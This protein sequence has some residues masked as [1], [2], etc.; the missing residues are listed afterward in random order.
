MKTAA[1]IITLC[2]FGHLAL[3]ILC[4]APNVQSGVGG[5][6]DEHCLQIV[7]SECTFSIQLHNNTSEK[8]D[9]T[10]WWFD[11][12][13]NHNGSFNIAGGELQPGQTEDLIGIRECGIYWV[14]WS[15]DRYNHVYAFYQDEIS[16]NPRVLKPIAYAQETMR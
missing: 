11:H 7:Q 6:K 2:W 14:R 9:Y 15:S 13:Y 12:P 4:A 8:V 10:L 1:Q 5:D 3:F 16:P